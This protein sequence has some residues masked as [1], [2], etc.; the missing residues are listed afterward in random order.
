MNISLYIAKRYLF[1]KKSHN[2]INVIS[3]IS[4]CGVAFVSF[5]LIVVL[6]AFNGLE[7]LVQSLYESFDPDI[8]I[9]PVTGK[10]FDAEDLPEEKIRQL[11]GVVNYTE[12]IEEFALLNYNQKQAPAVVKGVE[13]EFLNM[14]G[15]DTMLVD[16]ELLLEE[17]DV[18]YAVIGYKIA[19]NLSVNLADLRHTI[20]VYAPKR[21]GTVSLNPDQA[22]RSKNIVPSGIFLISPEFDA[23]YIIVPIDFTQ[24]LF[25][26]ENERSAIEIKL[27]EGTDEEEVQAEIQNLVGEQF[28][29]KTRRQ[30]NEIVYKTNETEKWVTFLILTF[31]LVIAAFNVIGSLTMLILDKKK[32]IGILKSMGASNGMIR[33]IFLAEGLLINFLG[34]F[35]GLTVGLV[36][37]Y[38]Q[39][40]YGLLRLEGGIVEFYPIRILFMDVVSILI[41]VFVIGFIASYFPVRVF[42]RYYF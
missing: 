32:D 25:E 7:Q 1:A 3:L 42:T 31:I 20:L 18:N 6:S 22:F 34:A 17:G 16:G 12:V 33:R 30:L 26:Y 37:C 35:I 5:A 27:R 13:R 4:V 9:T 28:N 36:L 10:T 15:M 29:V 11:P 14:T 38:L 23:R 8:K 2:V 39:M 21:G 40:E 19:N 24:E 41:A